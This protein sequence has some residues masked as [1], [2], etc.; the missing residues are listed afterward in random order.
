MTVQIDLTYSKK[1]AGVRRLD[2]TRGCAGKRFVAH[3]WRILGGEHRL[4]LFKSDFVMPP[5]WHKQNLARME[6]L[7]KQVPLLGNLGMQVAGGRPPGPTA[8]SYSG[9]VAISVI[10]ATIPRV[11]PGIDP[12]LTPTYPS[13]HRDAFDLP[14]RAKESSQT[15]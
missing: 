10:D 5:V 11:F 14:H 2:N 9:S 12:P 7:G 8:M 4:V 1:L 13:V 3:I 6:V 15:P